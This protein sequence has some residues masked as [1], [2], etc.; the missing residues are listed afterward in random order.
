M[1]QIWFAIGS[2]GRSYRDE[3]RAGPAAVR[4]APLTASWRSVP[5]PIGAGT[6]DERD[7]CG[8]SNRPLEER[9]RIECACIPPNHEI[10]TS[11]EMS[12]ESPVSH[13]AS[14]RFQGGSHPQEG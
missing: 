11:Q 5:A 1:P 14:S 7:E 4:Q 8:E 9:C 3:L 12:A 2:R 13:V 10:F 6:D